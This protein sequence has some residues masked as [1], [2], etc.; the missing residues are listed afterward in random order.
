MD[1]LIEFSQKSSEL[2]QDFF[3]PIVLN[4]Q[5]NYVLG[6]YSLSTYNSISNI[7]EGDNDLIGFI[8]SGEKPKTPPLV[9][10][11][12]TPGSRKVVPE[13]ASYITQQLGQS[14]D[15]KFELTYNETSIQV[16]INCNS[17]L[18]NKKGVVL[19]QLGFTEKTLSPGQH[20]SSKTFN[21]IP[22]VEIKSGKDEE[23]TFQPP[24]PT[25][26]DRTHWIKIPTGS[27]EIKQLAEY[28]VEKTKS[29]QIEFSLK[30]NPTTMRVEMKS[31]R[32]IVF[33]PDG[34]ISDLLGFQNNF[35]PANITHISEVMPQISSFNVINVECN[36][37]NTSF[38]NGKKSHALY[39]FT[40]NVG[41]GYKIV[42]KPNHIL[43]LPIRDREI[44]NISLRLTD[45]RGR[46]IFFNSEEITIHL[47]LREL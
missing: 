3:P 6:L 11:K 47:V 15:V 32:E 13:L 46:L 18:N 44:T 42:E 10:I 43:F 16:N 41:I 23:I 14:K 12:I 7:K 4:P 24:T 30:I 9:R 20:S 39:T 36:I 38:R 37:V 40:P 19:Q 27:Y 2:S 35:Y 28:L 31:D 34:S 25:R 17:L 22:S 1:R 26:I 5:S 8:F 33:P 21:A 45:H 29:A